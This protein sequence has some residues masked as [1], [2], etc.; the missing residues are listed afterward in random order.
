MGRSLAPLIVP[1]R[2][3][4]IVSRSIAAP[5]IQTALPLSSSFPVSI[6]LVSTSDPGMSTRQSCLALL[7]GSAITPWRQFYLRSEGTWPFRNTR[8]CRSRPRERISKLAFSTCPSDKNSEYH[9]WHFTIGSFLVT[10]S[11]SVY[12][13]MHKWK[14]S[15]WRFFRTLFPLEYFLVLVYLV[16]TST[17]GVVSSPGVI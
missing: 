6:C 12:S 13:L 9:G 1:M 8:S 10:I 17:L 11:L 2:I 16:L 7:S 4:Y 3:G 5:N 14:E 15:A